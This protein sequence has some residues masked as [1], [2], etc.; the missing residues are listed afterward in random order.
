MKEVNSKNLKNPNEVS[1][2]KLFVAQVLTTS[3]FSRSKFGYFLTVAGDILSFDRYCRNELKCDTKFTRREEIYSEIIKSIKSDS[4][5]LEFGVAHGYTTRFFLDRLNSNS[6]YIGFDLFTGL[7]KQWRN[8][9]MGQFTND[10][11]PP[12]IND[13]RLKWVIG[14]VIQ[15]F[16]LSFPLD[17]NLQHVIIF[18]LDLLE[19]TKH[20]FEILDS[21]GILTSETILYFDEAF[22]PEELCVIKSLLIPKFEVEVIAR[23]W[24]SIAFK[25]LNQK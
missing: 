6:K 4:V 12:E 5:V 13:E 20:A 24:S 15:T 11:K 18:D 23:N 8:F 10:G 9:E 2:V 22:D 17:K 1:R 16:K 19:P 14:D 21:M 25:I 3:I 7:P